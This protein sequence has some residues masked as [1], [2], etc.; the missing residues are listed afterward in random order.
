MSSERDEEKEQPTSLLD[1]GQRIPE[2][3][4][5]V[6]TLL[7]ALAIIG[8]VW[9]LHIAGVVS[10]GGLIT[11]IVVV[12]IIWAV[13]TNG[14]FFLREWFLVDWLKRRVKKADEYSPDTRA[15][16]QVMGLT[17]RPSR[18]RDEHEGHA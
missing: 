8:V 4:H 18:Q 17:H 14:E 10:Q 2:G 7:I 5:S 13:I 1:V 11:S 9:V 6:V 15:T 16:D 12:A 3:R